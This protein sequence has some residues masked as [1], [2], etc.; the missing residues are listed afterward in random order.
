MKLRI[1][2]NSIRL[3]LTR[4]EVERVSSGEV[5]K[6]T[7]RLPGGNFCYSLSGADVDEVRAMISGGHLRV[8]VPR[9]ALTRWHDGD[10]VAVDAPVESGAAAVLIEKD[11]ACLTPRPGSDDDDTYPHPDAGRAH[12]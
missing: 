2:G 10:A 1:L 9:D 5:L 8:T 3:R 7:T 6:E 11:Y 12:C 4:S